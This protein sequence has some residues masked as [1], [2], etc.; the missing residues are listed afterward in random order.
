MRHV[1]V[2][3]NETVAG[4]ALLERIRERAHDDDVR[5]TVLAPISNPRSGYVVYEDTRRASAGRRLE[6]SVKGLREAGVVVHGLVVDAEPVRAVRDALASIEPPI[7]EIPQVVG[8]P[9]EYGVPGARH[10]VL[11]GDRTAEE[12]KAH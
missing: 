9:Y 10:A 12:V 4:E 6:K 1:L 3:A 5:F 7:D 2:V 8:N 11:N